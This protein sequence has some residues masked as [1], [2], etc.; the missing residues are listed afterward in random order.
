MEFDGAS[1]ARLTGGDLLQGGPAGPVFT[2]SRHVPTNGW[3]VALPGDRFD[4]HDFLPA[5][6]GSVAAGAVVSR[7]PAAGLPW[8]RGLV[9]VPDSLRALQDLAGGVRARFTG[10]VV[11]ITGSVGKTT[12]RTLTVLALSDLGRVHHT[13]GNLNNHVGLPLTLLACPE[14]GVSALV[15]ELGM[16]ALG[17]IRRLQEISRPTVRLVTNV[18][19]AH[20]E[21][22]GTLENVALAKGELFD[23]ALPGDVL[24][25][26]A[27]DPRVFGHPRP[28]GCREVFYGSS[29]GCDVRLLAA[30]VDG[31]RQET[32][33]TV[34]VGGVRVDG[35]I[36]APGLH[37]ARNAVAALAVAWGLGLDPVRAARHLERYAPVGMRMRL[38]TLPGGIRVLNDAYNANP[39]SVRAALDTLA[40]LEGRRRVALLG[41]M[42]ELGPTEVDLHQEVLEDA[43]SHGFDLV[44]VCGPRMTAAAARLAVPHLLVFQDATAL[45]NGVAALLR[46]GD[47]VLVKGSRGMAMERVLLSIT[48]VGDR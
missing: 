48:P 9:R 38:E 35:R 26:N 20:L 1:I 27:D 5:I 41:D 24:C 2:D 15:L 12:T 47:L 6:A 29:Q 37:V 3:F 18:G 19:P 45:G 39:A 33:F 42:L 34:S 7:V 10:P 28:A 46:D 4:G 25:V 17:E 30:S 36:P 22:L 43:L 13:E 8:A 40:G 21:N 32:A 44:G 31:G 14:E 23:G 16:S 11:G